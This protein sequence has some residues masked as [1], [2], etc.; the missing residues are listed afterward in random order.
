MAREDQKREAFVYVV[1][2]AIFGIIYVIIQAAR[3]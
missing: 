2:F 3:R 1:V